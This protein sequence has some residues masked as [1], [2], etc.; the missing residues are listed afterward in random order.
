[1]GYG[2]FL[3]TP[4]ADRQS[5][6]IANNA[7][8]TLHTGTDTWVA[9]PT[10]PL[11]EFC[12]PG[13]PYCD[14][15][16]RYQV[17]VFDGPG[18]LFTWRRKSSGHVMT[19][20]QLSGSYTLVGLGY[21]EEC[22]PD[23]VLSVFEHELWAMIVGISKE[24]SH[25]YGRIQVTTLRWNGSTFVLNQGCTG[26]HFFVGATW[27]SQLSGNENLSGISLGRKCNSP[28]I[29]ANKDGQVSIVWAEVEPIQLILTWGWPFYPSTQKTYINRGNVFA[30]NGHING[31]DIEGKTGCMCTAEPC[32]E[33]PFRQFLDG[34][35]SPN[36]G[37]VLTYYPPT[38]SVIN[39]WRIEYEDFCGGVP[40]GIPEESGD[41][42]RLVSFTNPDVCISEPLG[43][44]GS[45]VTYT[46]Y[47]N[48]FN[49]E[50]YA[51]G[52]N[53]MIV[54]QDNW[55]NCYWDNRHG[56]SPSLEYPP[57]AA[58]T[59]DEY[60]RK[61]NFT[62]LLYGVSRIAAPGSADASNWQDFTLVQGANGGFCD[63][64]LGD[65]IRSYVRVWGRRGTDVSTP[66]ID[67]NL[68]STEF[69]FQNG[70]PVVAH[71]SE[72]STFPNRFFVAWS[73][74][75]LT[76]G[77]RTDVVTKAYELAFPGG[78]PV[79]VSYAATA[80]YPA[81]NASYSFVNHNLAGDQT[82][83]SIAS[84][85][86]N[87]TVAYS[88]VS[89]AI[90]RE[91]QKWACY[92]SVAEGSTSLDLECFND[93]GGQN[94]GEGSSGTFGGNNRRAS[95]IPYPSENEFKISLKL[96]PEETI[97]KAEIFDPQG[98]RVDSF[99]TP[100]YVWK[101]KADLPAGMYTVR[102]ETNTGTLVKRLLRE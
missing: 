4:L 36:P 2:Q 42:G 88:W 21:A 46:F 8:Q 45:I 85:H 22:D 72:G 44:L 10:D 37:W 9:D 33:M 91:M 95:V 27:P 43:A 81:Y 5:G 48:G 59:T 92:S 77:E 69:E 80:G 60:F 12:F 47:R 38:P 78:A 68:E 17:D 93:N 101:P 58:S 98:K 94:G 11:D 64:E 73:A 16:H 100:L 3:N 63:G 32:K 76:G 28:N 99:S 14:D 23:V 19:S 40:I 1:M 34:A 55:S 26:G 25:G 67:L 86:F 51:F 97:S 56:S 15:F 6:D 30:L 31:T 65:V 35:L 52:P 66:G 87:E 61:E 20:T 49:P 18:G 90:P 96:A 62:N 50:G 7:S 79:L 41:I 53:G 39:R 82:V 70:G 84:R 54:T 57:M 75:G 83:V 24:G 13:T 29:D 89:R 74:Y 71:W 102:I